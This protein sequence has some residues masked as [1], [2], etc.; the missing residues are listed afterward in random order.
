MHPDKNHRE[1]LLEM[2]LSTSG[3]ESNKINTKE[4]YGNSSL[5][6]ANQHYQDPRYRTD[7]QTG[8][9][10][11]IQS[12]VGLAGKESKHVS[13]MSSEHRRQPGSE[14]VTD[15]QATGSRAGTAGGAQ[16]VRLLYKPQNSATIKKVTSKSGSSA[17]DLKDHSAAK[18]KPKCPSPGLRRWTSAERKDQPPVTSS[19]DDH[20]DEI[21]RERRLLEESTKAAAICELCQLQGTII[22]KNCPR[23]VCRHCIVIYETDLC[24][25]TKGQHTFTELPDNKMPQKTSVDSKTD[26]SQGSANTNEACG[27]GGTNWPCSRCTYLNYPEH[28][29]CLVCGATRGIDVVE[30]AKPGSRVCWNCTLHNEE[31]AVECI[32]CH[33]PLFKSETTV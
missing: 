3:Q 12:N 1:G 21:S 5:N 18:T 10:L 6:E 9:Q 16:P 24:E 28:R 26:S 30:S 19:K 29:I 31:T 25:V 32:A 4:K 13:S 20:H 7:P 14:R 8:H 17:S 15:A 2:H 22:C 27:N 23:I 33:N 11:T